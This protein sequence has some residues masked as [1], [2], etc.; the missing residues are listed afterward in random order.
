MIV[1]SLTAGI[2]LILTGAL[3]WRF[4]LLTFIAG[5]RSDTQTDKAG[6]A[7]WIG[8][9]MIIMGIVVGVFAAIQIMLFQDTHI[10]VDS[11]IIL[12][13]STR[14]AMGAPKFSKPLGK[15]S[16]KTVAKEKKRRKK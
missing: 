2:V 11:A 8:K 13:L 7:K 5:N 15:S 9:N 14:M 12:V 6:L 16:L 4:K 3:V 10:L 1:T